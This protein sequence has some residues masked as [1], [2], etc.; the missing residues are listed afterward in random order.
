M[1]LSKP[2]DT[3]SKSCLTD[4]VTAFSAPLRESQSLSTKVRERCLS[5]DFLANWNGIVS[6]DGTGSDGILLDQDYLDSWK[7]N[8]KIRNVNR[9]S[10]SAEALLGIAK[11]QHCLHLKYSKSGSVFKITSVSR[12]AK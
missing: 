6:V 4:Y 3:F 9:K 2:E 10:G 5:K 7:T 11:E 12:C 1:A 8:I